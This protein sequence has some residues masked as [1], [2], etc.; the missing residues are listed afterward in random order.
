[1]GLHTVLKALKKEEHSMRILVL[2]LD[3]SG[4][5]TIVKRFIGEDIHS[6]SPTLGFN[7]V[8]TFHNGFR[9]NLM[10][11]GGQK[12]I[13]AYWK[14]HFEETDAVIWVIDSADKIRL[15]ETHD[16]LH[17]VLQAERLAGASLLVCANKQDIEGALSVEEITDVLQLNNIERRHWLC[18][19]VS[20]V[21]GRG[22]KEAINWVVSDV[23][24]RVYQFE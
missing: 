20:A 15:E 12:T 14:N 1:M 22:L 5:T 6:I 3:N 2:G 21:T 23:A 10:D 4:K 17:A 16:E 11:V 8:T 19:C 7:T 9:I 24:N 18:A 13:R